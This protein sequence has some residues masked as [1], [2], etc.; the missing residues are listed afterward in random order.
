MGFRKS[1]ALSRIQP[2]ATIAITQKARD[3]RAAGRD[4]ISLSIGEPDFDTPDHIKAASASKVAAG[5]T[6]Y[7]P[8]SGIPALQEAIVTKFRRENGLEY[9]SSQIIVSAGGKQVISNALLATLDPGDE[10]I[11]PAPY[12]VSYTQL[13]ILAGAIP[14]VVPTSEA[15][16]FLMTPAALEAAI[17]KNTRWLMLNSP[18]NPSGAVYS[19]EALKALAD[20]LERHPQVWVLSDDIYEHLVYGDVRFATMAAVAPALKERTLTMNGVSKAYA[21]T[22]WRIGYAGGPEPL[23]KAMSL[24]Q[25]QLTG[26]AP[27]ASQWAAHAALSGPQD[28][29]TQRRAVFQQRRDL[30]LTGIRKIPGM[31]CATPRGAFYVFPSCAS[32]VGKTTRQGQRIESD[33][34]FCMALLEEEG[35]A[36]VPGAAFG[37]SPHFRIS[38]AASEKELSEAIDRL[39]RFCVGLE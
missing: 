39:E 16:G 9:R 31:T 6:K 33:D 21:M 12:W 36:A 19:A 3:M 17:T 10:V 27:R 38:Y 2:S 18:S 20:V 14:V 15:D 35:V 26:G 37:A 24:M 8:V 13:V 23:I 5:E 7:P 30:V 4:V 11:I 29:L 28:V 25:S 34:D 32:F 1:A 22:G